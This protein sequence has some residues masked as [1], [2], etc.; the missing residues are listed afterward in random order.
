MRGRGKVGQERECQKVPKDLTKLPFPLVEQ[1]SNPNSLLLPASFHRYTSHPPRGYFLEPHSFQPSS[2]IDIAPIND[3]DRSSFAV[4]PKPVAIV[5][6]YFVNE[7]PLHKCGLCGRSNGASIETSLRRFV[8]CF[9]DVT[10]NRLHTF[11]RAY[12]FRFV[13]RIQRA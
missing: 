6:R 3:S 10:H 4:D 2:S 9:Q 7:L 12:T 5:C 11:R 8:A 1:P 13:T